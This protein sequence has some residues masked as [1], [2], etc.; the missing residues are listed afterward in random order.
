MLNQRAANELQEKPVLRLSLWIFG[1]PAAF[2]QV[3]RNGKVVGERALTFSP[4]T[5]SVKNNVVTT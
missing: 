2:P 1:E 5:E 3:V 4:R